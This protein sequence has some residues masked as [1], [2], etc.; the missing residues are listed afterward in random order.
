MAKRKK[1][2]RKSIES[3]EYQIALHEEK[4]AKAK[5]PELKRYY[6]KEI[7][8]FKRMLERKKRIAGCDD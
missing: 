5:T 8:E 6:D 4:R 3:I 2:A 1:R 7:D